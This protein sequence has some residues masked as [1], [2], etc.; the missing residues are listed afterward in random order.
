MMIGITYICK[1]IT[2]WMVSVF[3][4]LVILVTL[5][6][7]ADKRFY[8]IGPHDQFI[9]IGFVIDTWW[10]YTLLVMYS[11]CN[12][13]VRTV[14]HEVLSPWLVNNIQDLDRAILPE[15]AKYAYQVASINTLYQ[16]VDWL[17][18]MNILLSQIDMVLVEM[19]MNLIASNATTYLYIK[20]NKKT[21]FEETARL[22]T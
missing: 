20:Y 9:I 6:P 16:W 7:S 21:D 1:G 2:I 22:A 17:L 4:L 15:T 10:K 3:V 18:Y 8:R 19:C 11:L 5:S 13:I 12:T 14:Q